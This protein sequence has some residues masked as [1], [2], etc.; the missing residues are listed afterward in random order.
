MREA[1][2]LAKER[3]T[4]GEGE[5][6]GDSNFDTTNTSGSATVGGSGAGEDGE[7]SA[8]VEDENEDKTSAEAEKESEPVTSNGTK[9]QVLLREK[10]PEAS[11][12][13]KA[14]EFSVAFCYLMSKKAPK[15]LV[16]ALLRV[17][18]TRYELIPT[19]ARI[20]A[21]LGRLFPEIV[22]PLLEGLHKEF[23]GIYKAKNQ[24]HIENKVIHREQ[25]ILI[26]D[27]VIV[28]VIIILPNSQ[29]A[30]LRHL[31]QEY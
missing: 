15:H 8:W 1:W 5:T 20:A 28:I 29:I 23:I 17:P 22:K 13:Q 27:I 10:L 11:S 30:I 7:G 31:D 18:R 19:Y 24:Q 26:H 21:S 25:H 3:Q 9:L 4:T 2:K 6:E 12:K 16:A 14:D